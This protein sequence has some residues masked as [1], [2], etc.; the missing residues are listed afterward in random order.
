MPAS[1]HTDLTGVWDG[2]FEY[3]RGYEATSFTCVLIDIGGALSGTVTE[4][5][6]NGPTKGQT[7]TATVQGVRHD[8]EVRFLKTYPPRTT[9]HD[10]P[11]VYVGTLSLDGF[12]IEGEWTVPGSWSGRFLMIRSEGAASATEATTFEE[13][14]FV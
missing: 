9:N 13:V 12:E 4:L 2:Q 10:Q 14:P 8:S 6:N 3:P 7:L 1:S 11:A 5:S